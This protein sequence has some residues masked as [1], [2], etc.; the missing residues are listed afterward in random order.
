MVTAPPPASRA[1]EPVPLR[2]RRAVAVGN[3]PGEVT[4]F[5]GREGDLARLRALQAEARLLTLVGPGGV[6]KTRLA[7]RLEAD[8]SAAFPDGTGWS[9]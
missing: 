2:P 5:V 8:L 6:G 1:Q 9:T 7:L 4:D 3:V